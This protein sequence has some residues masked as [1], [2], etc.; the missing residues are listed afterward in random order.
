M[1]IVSGSVNVNIVGTYT[2]TYGV[3]DDSLLTASVMR[4]I[5]VVDNAP[6]EPPTD[7]IITW[8]MIIAWIK[9]TIF[10]RC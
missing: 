6:P 2:L 8:E 4:T 9:C 1:V 7:V 5:N 10:G 3:A